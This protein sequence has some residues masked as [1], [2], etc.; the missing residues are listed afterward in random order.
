M[1]DLM[2][3]GKN[4]T[5]WYKRPEKLVAYAGLALLGFVLL[6]GLN[7]ILPLI[8]SVLQNLVL[9]VIWGVGLT[10]LLWLILNKDLHIIFFAYYEKAIK[11]LILKDPIAVMRQIIKMFK[12]KYQEVVEAL[13]ELRGQYRSLEQLINE[14][15]SN[16]EKSMKVVQYAQKNANANSDMKLQM[17]LQSRKA[18]RLIESTE[19]YTS[20]LTRVGNSIKVL[21]KIQ[22]R[23]QY[24]ILDREDIANE[25]EKKR[26]AI[27]ST[28]KAVKASERILMASR[29]RD[30]YDMALEGLNEDSFRKLGA[31]EQ[32]LTD[33][34]SFINGMDIQNGIY[35]EDALVRLQE[36][37]Q[38]FDETLD[39]GKTKVIEAKAEPLLLNES[40]STEVSTTTG[41]FDSL[42][43]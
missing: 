28:L 39:N 3:S 22:E 26:K 27:L 35:E 13:G 23:I 20:L 12:A 5:P 10:A 14:N 2:T 11:W 18:G 43:K 6:N 4:D 17:R 32:F 24:E 42:F 30:M 37:E 1:T 8:V 21:E 7:I 38:K 25:A 9:T 19:T 41:K 33:S 29:E 15:K 31:I 16:Y 40:N 34:R 36:W